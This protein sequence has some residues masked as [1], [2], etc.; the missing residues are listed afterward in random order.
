MIYGSWD[1]K[2]NGQNF[3]SIWAIFCTFSP[4]TTQKI[5]I[6]KKWKMCLDISPFTKNHDHMLHCSWD[7]AHDR[8]IV[9]FNFELFLPFYP[10]PPPS[11]SLKNHL[12][13]S[14]IYTSVP[15]IM[16][17]CYTVPKIWLFAILDYLLPFYPSNSPKNQN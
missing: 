5:K 4:L 6:L 12:E 3:L 8:L 13:I 16:M 7:T 15:K 11:N 14:S 1:V 10:P 9:I 17:I 2:Q